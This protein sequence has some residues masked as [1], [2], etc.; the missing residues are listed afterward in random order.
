MWGGFGGGEDRPQQVKTAWHLAAEF[1][2]N[3][4][5]TVGLIIV[6]SPDLFCL[7]SGQRQQLHRYS[8]CGSEPPLNVAGTHTHTHMNKVPNSAKCCIQQL[9]NLTNTL[10][11]HVD[12]GDLHQQ[13]TLH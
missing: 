3:F 11:Q 8:G 9:I 10:N 2:S 12:S 4:T 13:K 5:L 1:M 6:T 7:L